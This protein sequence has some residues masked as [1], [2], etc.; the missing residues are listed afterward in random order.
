MNNIN[1]YRFRYKKGLYLIRVTPDVACRGGWNGKGTQ[2]YINQIC[3]DGETVMAE[4]RGYQG[5]HSKAAIIRVI[6]ANGWD[7]YE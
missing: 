1:E 2:T 6:K 4:M 5:R 3:A 7:R